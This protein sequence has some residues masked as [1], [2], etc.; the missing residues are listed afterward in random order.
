MGYRS[1]RPSVTAGHGGFA[2][3]SS[4]T[5]TK[6]SATAATP[7]ARTPIAAD[8]FGTFSRTLAF[9]AGRFFIEQA[10]RNG[11]T[12]RMLHRETDRLKVARNRDEL[13]RHCGR[14]DR[15]G[16]CSV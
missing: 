7:G 14:H 3:P 5:S 9:A 6:R 10:Q 4:A 11:R 8:F 16:N 2:A 15:D 13:Q 12:F 1:E